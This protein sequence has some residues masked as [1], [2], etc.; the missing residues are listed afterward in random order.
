SV[1]AEGPPPIPPSFFPFPVSVHSPFPFSPLT[2]LKLDS[3]LLI[4]LEIFYRNKPDMESQ[5][6]QYLRRQQWRIEDKSKWSEVGIDAVRRVHIPSKRRWKSKTKFGFVRFMSSAAAEEAMRN[7]NGV[8]CI[9]KRITVQM[10]YYDSKPKDDTSD[11]RKEEDFNI[12]G[13]WTPNGKEEE[14]LAEGK[15]GEDPV[16]KKHSS[17][18][19]R[20]EAFEIDESW[21]KFCLVGVLKDPKGGELLSEALYNGGSMSVSIKAIGCEKVLIMFQ[22]IEDKCYFQQS[23]R[24]MWEK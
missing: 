6:R 9:D 18:Q 10:A 23:H 7:V 20:V 2:L 15:E 17:S 22:T 19:K 21:T 13:R 11:R 8:W 24:D 1:V 5:R 14:D 3:P 16:E 12:K 4:N